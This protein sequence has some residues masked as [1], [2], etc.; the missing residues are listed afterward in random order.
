MEELRGGAAPRGAGA[1]ERVYW[2]DADALE[3]DATVVSASGDRVVLD[4]TVF[5]PEG[6]GQLGDSG[7]LVAAGGREL[8]VKDT[9]LEGETIVHLLE[10]PLEA[11]FAGAVRCRVDGARRRDHTAHHTAQHILSRAL[12]DEAGAKTASARLGETG[13]TLDVQR[14][15]IPEAE[16]VRAEDVANDVVLRDV[17]VRAF[18]PAPEELARLTLRRAPK[19]DRGVRVVEVEGFDLTPCGG[20]HVLRTGRIGSIRV[21]GVE[22]YKG[23]T[24][25]SFAAERRAL[26]DARAKDAVLTA[27]ARELTCGVAAVPAGIAKLRADLKERGDALSAAR[28]ELVA[29]VVLAELAAHPPESSGTTTVRLERPQG[30]VATLRALAAGLSARPDVVAIVSAA[31][32]E[33]GDDFVVV[34]RGASASFDCAAWLK[35]EAARRGGRGGGKPDRA[36]GRLGRV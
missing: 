15:A 28:G 26:A 31:D 13:C 14:A 5:Y 6:G 21:L 34:Q 18:F 23:M 17:P 10:R 4:R 30:D 24:R 19:V 33:G 29:R 2:A 27:L 20:T 9:A 8:R 35:A 25:V 11:P 16:L 3:A 12:E 32:P 7:L 36:E 22:R 1:T